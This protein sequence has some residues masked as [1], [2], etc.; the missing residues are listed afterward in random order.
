MQNYY[1]ACGS[2]R[3]WNLVSDIKGGIGTE[4]VWEH[5]SEENIEPKKDEVTGGWR[6]LHTEELHNLYS[7]PSHDQVKEDEMGRACSTNWGQRGM[8]IGYWWEN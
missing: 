7:S 4:G 1:F 3:V 8:H 5:G 2:V 6:K